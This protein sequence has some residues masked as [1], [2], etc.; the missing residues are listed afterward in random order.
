MDV[1][2]HSFTGIY[3]QPRGV[4]RPGP[5]ACRPPPIQPV[6][7]RQAHPPTAT[8]KDS[9]PGGIRPLGRAVG[10][11]LLAVGQ[12]KRDSL[13]KPLLSLRSRRPALVAS[14]DLRHGG[15][16]HCSTLG[17]SPLNTQAHD[18][19]ISA[20]TLKRETFTPRREFP[21]RSSDLPPPRSDFP[22]AKREFPF[23]QR[24]F[25]TAKREFPFGKREFPARSSDLPQAGRE[26][27]TGHREF[28]AARRGFTLAKSE[29]PAGGRGFPRRIN[30]KDRAS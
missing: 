16:D 25:P 11:S 28:P 14:G 30:Q 7:S 1:V 24:E 22:T 21:A 8:A 13:G 2:K 29:F 9:G 12:R 3:A 4:V 26:L 18:T 5:P 20:E 23:E 27:P 10:C 15:R 19:C 6:R 17:T